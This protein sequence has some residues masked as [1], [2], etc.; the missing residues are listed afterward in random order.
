MSGAVMVMSAGYGSHF[1]ELSERGMKNKE[2]SAIGKATLIEL[3]VRCNYPEYLFEEVGRSVKAGIDM[4]DIGAFFSR[5]GK[6][7]RELA[8]YMRVIRTKDKP[9]EQD[10][11]HTFK[12]S[13]NNAVWEYMNAS[14]SDKGVSISK[15]IE[16]QAMFIAE[17]EV[18]SSEKEVVKQ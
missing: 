7:N 10:L 16:M 12:V 4:T 8:E 6:S 11:K 17:M 5:S 18:A 15:L 2:Y 3:R 1:R 14:A 13:V 9:T